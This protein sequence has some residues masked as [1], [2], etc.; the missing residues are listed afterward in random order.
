MQ[1]EA[2]PA[3]TR[4]KLI[5]AKHSIHFDLHF[6][7]RIGKKMVQ[8]LFLWDWI[9]QSVYRESRAPGDLKMIA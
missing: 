6:C 7:K 1:L 8:S 3:K 4:I 5:L 9:K 2:R